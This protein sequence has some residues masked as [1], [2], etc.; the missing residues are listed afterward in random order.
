MK[1]KSVKQGLIQSQ[2]EGQIAKRLVE[3]KPGSFLKSLAG[4]LIIFGLICLILTAYLTY[5]RYNPERLSF[6]NLKSQGQISSIN[7]S[8]TPEEISVA[9]L[10]IILPIIPSRINEGRWEATTKGVSYLTTSPLPG[11]KGNSV[12]Y[13]HNFPNLLGNLKKI[14]PGQKIAI[15]YT[16]GNIKE[17]IV[18][19]TLEVSPKQTNILETSDDS[20][21]TLYTCSGFFDTKRF[22]VI[23]NPQS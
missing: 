11:E 21:I 15:K 18:S 10:N 8:Q 9:D 16:D 1:K 19:Y 23:A 12:L 20:R 22:V 14:K 6:E 13:G 3:N 17:F 7:T 5:Q 2:L 4:F